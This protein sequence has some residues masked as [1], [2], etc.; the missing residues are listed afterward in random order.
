MGACPHHKIST[1]VGSKQPHKRE[2]YLTKKYS[3]IIATLHKIATAFFLF[4]YIFTILSYSK[5]IE[6]VLECNLLLFVI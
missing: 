2:S 3:T 5:R 4:L 1:V 6:L